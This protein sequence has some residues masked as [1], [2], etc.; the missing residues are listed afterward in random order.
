MH[1]YSRWTRKRKK[2]EEKVKNWTLFVELRKYIET[3]LSEPESIKECGN[4]ISGKD[5]IEREVDEWTLVDYKKKD[6]TRIPFIIILIT[7]I[8]MIEYYYHKYW[9]K[10]WSEMRY[11]KNNVKWKISFKYWKWTRRKSFSMEVLEDLSKRW[12]SPKWRKLI[13]CLSSSKFGCGEPQ[14]KY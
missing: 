14:R 9:I 10:L 8:I 7:Q 5:L 12:R 3:F 11:T 4:V 1:V 13:D 6:W 2:W